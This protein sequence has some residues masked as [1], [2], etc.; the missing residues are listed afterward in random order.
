MTFIPELIIHSYKGI[1]VNV[2]KI[3]GFFFRISQNSQ[4]LGKFAAFLICVSHFQQFR[5]IL[6]EN[7]TGYNFCVFNNLRFTRDREKS[8][9]RP[10]R[11]TVSNLIM[12]NFASFYYLQTLSLTVNK[13]M[14]LTRLFCKLLVHVSKKGKVFTTYIVRYRFCNLS[15]T[16]AVVSSVALCSRGR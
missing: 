10:S 8:K 9:I 2:P 5:K 6:M 16:C 12:E 4:K 1:H 3:Q 13:I 15:A 11:Y 14:T 7:D